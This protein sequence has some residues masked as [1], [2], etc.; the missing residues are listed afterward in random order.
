MNE[1]E[2]IYTQRESVIHAAMIKAAI[3]ASRGLPASEAVRLAL[4]RECPTP[5]VCVWPVAPEAD[6]DGGEI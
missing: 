3:E 2:A 1:N 4:A 6:S 5:D